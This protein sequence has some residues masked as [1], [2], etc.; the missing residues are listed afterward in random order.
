MAGTPLK[1]LRIFR[2]LCGK[3]ALEKVYLTTTMWDEVEP[4]DGA[5]RLNELHTVYWKTMVA[6]GAHIACCRKDDNSVKELIRRILA[7]EGRRKVLLQEEMVERGKVLRETAAGQE[8]YSQLEEL[9]ERQMELLRRI[10]K[11]RKAAAEP[12][13]LMDLQREYDGLH[14]QINDKLRQ[15]KELK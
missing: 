12:R 6:Q 8:L 7:Q 2:K 11:E 5:S 3:D 4:N 15:M 14:A 9:A 10:D 1:N 13:M